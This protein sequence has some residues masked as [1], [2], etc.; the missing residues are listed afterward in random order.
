MMSVRHNP[1]EPRLEPRR[2]P[3]KRRRGSPGPDI[4]PRNPGAL[5]NPGE[6]TGDSPDYAR[7][8]GFDVMSGC[9]TDQSP[10]VPSRIWDGDFRVRGGVG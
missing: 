4:E 3:E 5:E 2:T 7:G 10:E 8:Q 1:G 6:N 9:R